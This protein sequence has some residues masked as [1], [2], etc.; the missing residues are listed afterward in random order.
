MNCYGG[1]K[2]QIFILQA[3]FEFGSVQH[4]NSPQGPSK[5]HPLCRFDIAYAQ[6][7]ILFMRHTLVFPSMTYLGCLFFPLSSPHFCSLYKL[8]MTSM[9]VFSVSTSPHI[10]FQFFPL[11]FISFSP[12]F[13]SALCFLSPS[14]ASLS[15]LLSSSFA[16][17][18]AGFPTSDTFPLSSQWRHEL[19]LARPC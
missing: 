12:I 8:M 3:R 4:K 2:S 18:P 7:I 6:L 5:E 1:F 17:V 19:L 13:R 10:S 15:L 9:C 16:R 11:F 14:R